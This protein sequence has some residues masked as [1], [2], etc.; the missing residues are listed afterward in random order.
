[1]N[2]FDIFKRIETPAAA[3]KPIEYIVAGLGNPGDK[4]SRSKHNVGFNTLDLLSSK[5]GFTINHS[6]WNALYTDTVFCGRRV[7][8]VKPQTFMNNSGQ[9]VRDICDFYKIPPE[10]LIIIYDD[11]NLLPGCIRIRSKGSAGGHNGMK[12]IIFQL[13]SDNFPR[14]R[15]GVGEKPEGWD[16]ADWVLAPFSEDDGKKVSEA[17]SNACDALTVMLESGIDA[18]MAKY[19]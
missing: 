7:L 12:D 17:I 1:M 14:I 15:I 8:F 6:K 5:Q 2:I 4:Y 9:A 3:V 11:I 13:G 10:K 18:A 16:L 19:N